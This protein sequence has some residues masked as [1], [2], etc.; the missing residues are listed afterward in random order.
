LT[1]NLRALGEASVDPALEKLF[2]R[3]IDPGSADE[4]RRH[5]RSD[6]PD[7]TTVAAFAA[8]CDERVSAALATARIEDASVPRL[9]RGQAAYTILEHE[10]MHHET[11]LYIIHQL[12]YD[13]ITW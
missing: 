1:L 7:R 5:D 9:V 4:A 11:L 2:E 6:W 10:P 12:A 3:G 13:R 8:Q